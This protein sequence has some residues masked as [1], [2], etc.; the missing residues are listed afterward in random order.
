[1]RYR[2]PLKKCA[3]PVAI[4]LLLASVVHADAG[5]PMIMLVWPAAWLALIPV[6]LI[7]AQV[8]RRVLG[9]EA[10]QAIEVSTGANLA[11][12][13]VGIPLAWAGML[14]VEFIVTTQVHL[15]AAA[16]PGTWQRRLLVAV[17]TLSMSAWIPPVEGGDA[18]WMVPASMMVLSVGFF[19]ASVW[20]ERVAVRRMLP[21]ELHGSVRRWSWHANILSYFAI[22]SAL[23]ITFIA[24]TR[25][26]NW[27]F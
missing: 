20:V 13:I 3:T 1:M 16:D 26:D 15:P 2:N 27:P 4:L 19:F 11:S 12:T 17:Y 14:L 23:A 22:E 10:K 7:E 6:I 25:G 9:L 5:V 24:V 21:V 8:A 18:V